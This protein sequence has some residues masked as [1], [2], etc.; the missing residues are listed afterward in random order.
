[1]ARA[2]SVVAQV[3]GKARTGAAAQDSATGEAGVRWLLEDQARLG[4]GGGGGGGRE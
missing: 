2:G 3:A 4:G 1:M